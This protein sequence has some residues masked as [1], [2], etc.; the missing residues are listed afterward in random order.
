MYPKEEESVEKCKG[1]AFEQ[2]LAYTYLER[3]DKSKY[4][5]LLSGLQT[6]YLLGNNQFPQ[7]VSDKN[8]VLSNHRFDFPSKSKLSAMKSENINDN[9]IEESPESFFS[10]LDGRC[11]CCGKAGHKSPNCRWNSKLKHE[12]AINKIKQSNR[13]NGASGQSPSTTGSNSVT[14]RSSSATSNVMPGWSG[15]NVQ[16]YQTLDMKSCIL[17]DH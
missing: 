15:A 14:T 4:G 16:F 2:F 9:K 6:Q 10:Q 3:A 8:S 17:L 1:K 5:S 7:T 12:W 11:Y 13:K